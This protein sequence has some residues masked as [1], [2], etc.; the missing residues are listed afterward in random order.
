M[1]AL[2]KKKNP[3][4]V[5]KE[6]DNNFLG[7]KTN[8]GRKKKLEEKEINENSS[9][10]TKKT[11]DKKELYNVLNKVEVDC[12]NSIPESLNSFLDFVGHDKKERF[13]KI[14]PIY[15]KRVNKDF[16]DRK[17]KHKII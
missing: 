12:H 16:L 7:K 9:A 11:H 4:I 1:R 3:F 15:K 14:N 5:E 17:K 2:K 8:F 10:K 13:L 6:V